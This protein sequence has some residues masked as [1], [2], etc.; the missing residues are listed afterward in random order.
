MLSIIDQFLPQRC[1]NK[2]TDWNFQDLGRKDQNHLKG[3]IETL[4]KKY[5]FNERNLS[6]IYGSTILHDIL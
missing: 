4:S 3:G 5:H 1:Q 6:F 2:R